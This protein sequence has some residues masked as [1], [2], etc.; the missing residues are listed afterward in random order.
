[1]E[2][3][4]GNRLRHHRAVDRELL[5][6]AAATPL[7]HGAVEWLMAREGLDAVDRQID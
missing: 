3:A 5:D 4:P 2:P 1:M 7:T 6:E